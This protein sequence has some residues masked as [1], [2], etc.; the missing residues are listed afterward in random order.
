MRSHSKAVSKQIR[1]VCNPIGELRLDYPLLWIKVVHTLITS[2]LG[3]AGYRPTAS[4]DNASLPRWLETHLAARTPHYH[5]PDD[6]A[7]TLSYERMGATGRWLDLLSHLMD[8][9]R[10]KDEFEAE[11]VEFADEI[12]SFCRMTG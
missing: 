2:R 10:Q 11:R 6:R 3:E 1:C 9:G 12:E 8:E 5:T 7:E 4:S